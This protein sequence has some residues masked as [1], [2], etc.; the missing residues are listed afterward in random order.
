[1]KTKLLQCGVIA[2]SAVLLAGCSSEQK[3]EAPV[4]DSVLLYYGSLMSDAAGTGYEA[5]SFAAL[6]GLPKEIFPVKPFDGMSGKV[7]G[8]IV[9]TED[10]YGET[11][12]D[13]IVY[14][15]NGFKTKAEYTDKYDRYEYE[16][17]MNWT[18]DDKLVEESRLLHEDAE[19]GYDAVYSIDGI[20]DRSAEVSFDGNK[21]PVNRCIY[22]HTEYEED[23][24]GDEYLVPAKK[25]QL[26]SEE[27]W[28]YDAY[29]NIVEYAISL[30]GRTPDKW[31]MTYSED[32]KSMLAA[33]HVHSD[34]TEEKIRY[35]YY[36]GM[37]EKPAEITFYDKNGKRQKRHWLSYDDAGNLVEAVIENTGA[38]SQEIF[39]A[40]GLRLKYSTP[41]HNSTVS[42]E[43]D[44]IGNWTKRTENSD[45]GT[46]VE[47]R[48]ITYY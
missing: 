14:N 47:E 34:G 11:D 35:R 39:G 36:D 43:F 22:W 23:E 15:E 26:Y 45:Y 1:M 18:S 44:A 6:Y 19:G 8:V 21:R 9:R 32:G 38:F 41:T 40:G 42:Y 16:F 3:A 46:S 25:P 33:V 4:T 20:L 2:L 7:K 30:W 28:K 37:P 48:Q 31:E 17:S 5:E 10:Q 29:G 12:P 27:N 24:S 13:I